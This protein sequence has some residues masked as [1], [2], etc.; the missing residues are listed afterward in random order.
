M[1]AGRLAMALDPVVMARRAG[2]IADDWQSDMLRSTAPQTLLNCARQ[3]GKSTTTAA[4]AVWTALYD[5]GALVLLLS[6]SLRQSGELFRKCISVYGSLDRPVPPDS[7]TALQLRLDNGSRIISLPG[8]EET[9]RGFSG[10][11][12]LVVDEASRVPDDLYYSIRPMLAVSGGRL[13][14]L[15]TPAGKRGWWHSEWVEGG[16]S[17]QRV[18]VRAQDCPRIPAAF[19]EDERRHMPAAIF[20]A[21]YE[22]A[23]TDAEGSVFRWDDI[24]A[25]LVDAPP[26]FAMGGRM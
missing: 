23:F 10:V 11:R 4:L 8:R 15:S 21:E 6:P 18:Q 26:L 13:V 5:P 14:A 16:D 9:I 22:C 1:I 17:W 3:T 25:A 12:L 7:E 24:Q 20:A 19:L 2:I